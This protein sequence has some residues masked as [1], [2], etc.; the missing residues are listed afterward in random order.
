MNKSVKRT[1]VTFV[2]GHLEIYVISVRH[3]VGTHLFSH[4]ESENSDPD[5]QENMSVQ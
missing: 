1:N 4:L 5:H 3:D 2:G